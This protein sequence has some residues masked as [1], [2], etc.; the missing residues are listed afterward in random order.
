MTGVTSAKKITFET[1]VARV[2]QGDDDPLVRGPKG[3]FKCLVRAVLRRS[4]QLL[5]VIWGL[6]TSSRM[7]P[8]TFGKPR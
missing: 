8:E 7:D 3:G 1:A 6:S 2:N 4:T 5:S